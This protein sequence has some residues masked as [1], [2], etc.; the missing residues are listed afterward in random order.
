MRGVIERANAD[1]DMW[2]GMVAGHRPLTG[3]AKERYTE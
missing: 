2:V 1:G 3:H